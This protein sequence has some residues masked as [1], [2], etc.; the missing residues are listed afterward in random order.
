MRLLLI[1]AIILAALFTQFQ[2]VQSEDLHEVCMDAEYYDKCR[3]N[4]EYWQNVPD[5]I[6]HASE[7]YWRG[8]YTHMDHDML[9]KNYCSTYVQYFKSNGQ[10]NYDAYNSWMMLNSKFILES[11]VV[12]NNK[13]AVALSN[14]LFHVMT[15]LC[16]YILD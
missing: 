5:S 10:S 7:E 1:P 16:P 14:G 9:R 11:G 4:F 6:A 13:E 3:Q 12:S 2:S 8:F 15:E